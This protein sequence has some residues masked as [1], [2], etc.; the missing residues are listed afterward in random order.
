MPGRIVFVGSSSVEEG[1]PLPELVAARLGAEAIAAGRRGSRVRQWVRWLAE[2]SNNLP[3]V[4]RGNLVAVHLGGNE[5]LERPPSPSDVGA[6]DQALRGMG[7]AAVVWLPPPV[8][9]ESST[10]GG[11]RR[12]RGRR[13]QMVEA[14]EASGVAYV[15]RTVSFGRRLFAP[16][17]VHPRR[18]GYQRWAA[19][20]GAELRRKFSEQI[21]SR[22]VEA[23][24]PF[25]VLTCALVVGLFFLG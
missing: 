10:D 2:P 1:S 3:G 7:A 19:D 18:A 20:I 23:R 4:V 8:F 21:D 17:G 13:A 6:V 24:F 15:S 5:P 9:P 11:G 16:D 25:L 12:M 22:S 14:L